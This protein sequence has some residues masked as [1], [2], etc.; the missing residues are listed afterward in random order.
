VTE[1]YALETVDRHGPLR[2]GDLARRLHVEKS[3]ASRVVEALKQKGLVDRRAR[4][5]D[6]RAVRIV[7]T[8]KGRR[9]HERIAQEA[10]KRYRGLLEELPAASRPVVIGFLERLA[11]SGRTAEAESCHG[12][13][14]RPAFVAVAAQLV[15][16]WRYLDRLPGDRAGLTLYVLTIALFASAATFFFVRWRDGRRSAGDPGR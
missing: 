14:R 15:A 1:C 9:L 5:E 10:R 2:L 16:F 8:A 4:E 11:G 3:T 7:A 13:A 12:H 6:R